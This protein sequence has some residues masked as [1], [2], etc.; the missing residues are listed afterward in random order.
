MAVRIFFRGVMKTATFSKFFSDILAVWQMSL[1]TVSKLLEFTTLS[2]FCQKLRAIDSCALLNYLVS[3]FH[4]SFLSESENLVFQH[5]AI[6]V[7]FDFLPRNNFREN[8]I[9]VP[10]YYN[11]R[12]QFCREISP[13]KSWR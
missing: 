4:E 2:V 1:R 7:P 6:D 13:I 12:M 3:C 10:T 9:V 8:I 5:C 11:K